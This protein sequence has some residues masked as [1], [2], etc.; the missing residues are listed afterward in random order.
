MPHGAAKVLEYTA[1]ETEKMARQTTF[2]GAWKRLAEAAGGVGALA[3]RLGRN[4]STLERWASGDT[5]PIVEVKASVGVL[6]ADLG[7]PL[8]PFGAKARAAC[9]KAGQ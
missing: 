2:V 8:P 7:V 6:A 4:R 1:K 3:K 5:E 9:R